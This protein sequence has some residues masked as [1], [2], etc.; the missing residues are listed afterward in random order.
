MPFERFLAVVRRERHEDG[1]TCECE[2]REELLNSHGVL[3]GGVIASIA[4]EA[5][6]WAIDAHTT[7]SARCTTTELKINYLEPLVGTKVVARA[8]LLRIGKTLCVS[9]VDLSGE[10]G[11]LAAVGIVTYMFLP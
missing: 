1:I 6:W 10:D 3:H 8:I 11:K 7:L 2:I 5:A 4:D 9:R